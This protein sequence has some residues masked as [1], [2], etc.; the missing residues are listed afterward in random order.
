MSELKHIIDFL[1]TTQLKINEHTIFYNSKLY[2]YLIYKTKTFIE[3][4]WVLDELME[5]GLKVGKKLF[6]L[7]LHVMD[8][9]EDALFMLEL[10]R[11]NNISLDINEY[12][13]LLATTNTLTETQYILS[14][15]DREGF[16]YNPLIY[17]ILMEKS[18]SYLEAKK[19]FEEIK[20]IDPKPS[21]NT[22][23]QL[24]SKAINK[25]FEPKIIQEMKSL[26]YEFD[27]ELYS[28]FQMKSSSSNSAS[29]RNTLSEMFINI[30]IEDIFN[31]LKVDYRS[32]IY[33]FKNMLPLTSYSWYIASDN[34]FILEIDKSV[35][36]HNGAGVPANIRTFFNISDIKPSDKME[37]QLL[38]KDLSYDAHFEADFQLVSRTRLM[39]S[40]RFSNLIKSE[41]SDWY[42]LFSETDKILFDTPKIRFEK[43]DG[44][45]QSYNVEF[46]DPNEVKLD[47]ET[48]FD[49]YQPKLEG[50]I[51]YYYHKK[52]ERDLT[53][54][55][56][57]IEYHGTKCAICCFDFEKH[58]GIRG[59]GYIEIHHTSPLS[60]LDSE[61]IIDPKTDLVPVCSNCHKMIHRRKDNIL[62]IDEMK[63]IYNK[64]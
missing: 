23:H 37:V 38:Y 31:G 58:Y 45:D 10:K 46:I 47:A 8:N 19:V 50:Y 26:G 48:D 40:S 42:K 61:T 15:I 25:E 64:N 57:A 2:L 59:K 43:T 6:C 28:F 34:I 11:R 16:S 22:Y 53:N 30:S 1:K 51:K 17:G 63:K 27:E 33:E 56:K 7:T 36:L 32:S 62:S 52:Y 55:N 4:K 41:L 44:K 49:D 24:L 29:F 20:R 13:H 60:T 54:R 12:S 21:I 9:Y 14:L 35:F 5:L 18:S 39:W 3:V